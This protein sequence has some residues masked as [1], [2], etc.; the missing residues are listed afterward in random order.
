MASNDSGKNAQVWK[1][2]ADAV[3]SASVN[4]SLIDTVEENELIGADD[5]AIMA[6]SPC[7]TKPGRKACRNCTCGLAEAQL[8]DLSAQAGSNSACGSCHLGDAFRC[9]T[10]PYRGM[11]A[12]KPG[13]TVTISLKDDLDE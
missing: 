5:S 6:P 2:L 13:E 3:A 8:T 4:V 11:P 12:F 7:G 1:R 10:C 9:S